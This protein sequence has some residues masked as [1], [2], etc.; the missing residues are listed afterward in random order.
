MGVPGFFSWLLRKYKNN[1]II[2]SKINTPVNILYLDANCLIHPQCF[3][4]LD[5]H[6]DWKDINVLEN[7]MM[8]RVINYI[9]YLLNIV[10]PTDELYIAVDGVAPMAKMNQQRKRRYR[11]YDDKFLRDNIK[12]K[13]NKIVLVEYWSNEILLTA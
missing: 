5:L 7:K 13:H 10:N 4:V 6:P 9:D 12:K 11:S 2:T 8:N 1:S 3:K